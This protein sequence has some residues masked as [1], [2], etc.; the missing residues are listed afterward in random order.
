MLNLEGKKD[1][2]INLPVSLV[3]TGD[4]L[5]LFANNPSVIKKFK[6]REGSLKQGMQSEAYNS[7][8]V[9][10][11]VMNSYLEEIFI[12]LP[13]FLRKR[14][15]I[16]D[17]NNL[18]LY[19]ILYKKLSPSLATMLFESNVLKDYNRKNPKSLI[20]SLNHVDRAKL[21]ALRSAKKD[22]FDM[23]ETEIKNEVIQ[24]ITSN[25]EIEEEDK[26]VRMRSLEKFINY[27]DKRIWYLYFVIYQT[28]LKDEIKKHFADMIALYLDRT[29]LATHLS[30]LLMEF[31]QNAE[32][33]HFERI[34]VHQNMAKKSE[35]DK[36][37][38]NSE[39]RKWVIDEAK[40]RNQMLELSWNMNSERSSTG[41]NFKVQIS[42][43]NFGLIDERT[44]A[45]L[46]SKMKSDTSEI[47]VASF[48]QDS[49]D[50]DKLGAG[51]GLL[52]I[53][54]LE[55][56]CKKEGIKFF[57]NIFPEP[58]KEKTTV[59]IEITL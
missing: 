19:G 9:Q 21:D 41:N 59:K 2:Y 40:K 47:S 52:Y 56:I 1:P 10:K 51:L 45:S 58:S 48:Y 34:I 20:T 43:S 15:E 30:N 50:T 28:P 6:N 23:M 13:D 16:I 53:S 8:S 35:I 14:M 7:V 38:K 44:R 32:K 4:G 37:L 24:R 36:F 46:A 12:S 33:A 27:I 22:F 31:I 11:L 57:C 25:K 29:K 39:N 5:L 55:D 26:L 18:V 17:T 54:Y 42:L 49:G 3:L